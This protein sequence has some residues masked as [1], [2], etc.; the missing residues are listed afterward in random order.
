MPSFA[1]SIAFLTVVQAA[2]IALP[3]D[4]R[5]LPLARVQSRWWAIILPAWIAAG[6]GLVAMYETS[7]DALSLLALVAAPPLAA[8]ALGALMRRATAALAL[9]VVPLFALAWELRGKL[10]GETAGLTLTGLAC[11]TLGVLLAAIAP[12]RWLKLGIYAMAIVDVIFIAADLLQG[13]SATVTAAEPPAELPRLQA[14]Y[15]GQ[16][17]MAFGDFFIAAV[18]GAFLARELR[19]QAE[20]VALAVVL[21]LAFDLLFFATSPLPA[22]VPIAATLALLE[23]RERRRARRV[24]EGR[25]QLLSSPHS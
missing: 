19:A 22:T 10:L 20:A 15:F 13:P 7:A 25:E 2:L 14:V 4:G 21:G 16:A 9:A 12:S 23:A 18:V 5:R 1:V 17:T 6:V 24:S 11:V 8:V 3:G